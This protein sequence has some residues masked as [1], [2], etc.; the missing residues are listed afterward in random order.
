MKTESKLWFKKL[1]DDI[2][3]MVESYEESSFVEKECKERHAAGQTAEEAIVEIDLGVYKEWGE[4]E[5]LAVNVHA[6]YREIDGESSVQ[7]PLELF[8]AMAKLKSGV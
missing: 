5:R 1:R 3:S 6:I 2:I 7:S 8:S 4:W